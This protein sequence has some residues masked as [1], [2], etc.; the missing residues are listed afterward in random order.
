MRIVEHTIEFI[1]VFLRSFKMS[2]MK[3]MDSLGWESYR[4]INQ[5]FHE[6]WFNSSDIQDAD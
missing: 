2:G 5:V 4:T 1:S 6:Q 3:D